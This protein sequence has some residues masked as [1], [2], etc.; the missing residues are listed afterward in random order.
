M[1]APSAI[2]TS[3]W[4]GFYVGGHAG[5]AWATGEYTVNDIISERFTLD[6]G[7]FM[8]GGQL[9]VQAQWGHWV[10][11]VEGTYSWTDLDQTRPSAL[12]PAK[13]STVDIRQIGTVTGKLG[14]AEDRWMIYGKG[15]VAFGRVHTL[16]V[17]PAI[18]TTFDGRVWETGYTLG[19]G[20]DYMWLPNWVVGAE[21][22]YYNFSFNRS[23]TPAL[24]LPGWI[25]QSN[26]D[27]FAVMLRV[28]YLFN[29][30]W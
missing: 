18:A 27:V 19:L 26:A 30:R 12:V 6:P 25:T 16:D 23:F 8:G 15:G 2:L 20:V 13:S 28:N 9:G 3:N 7:G 10:F 14:W 24:G 29:M 11:G 17:N 4:A 1:R 21:F 5:Y 22:D